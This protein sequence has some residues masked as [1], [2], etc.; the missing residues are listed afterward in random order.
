MGLMRRCQSPRPPAANI[1]DAASAAAPA[2][3]AKG[4]SA[5]QLMLLPTG[6]LLPPPALLL[7]PLLP[8]FVHSPIFI[9]LLTLQNLTTSNAAVAI[10]PPHAATEAMT[11]L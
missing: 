3:E 2:A 10:T 9:P 7:L 1:I 5:V 4:F 11:S 6:L 8:P